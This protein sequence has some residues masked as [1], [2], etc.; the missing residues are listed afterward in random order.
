MKV[1]FPGL[2]VM[3]TREFEVLALKGVKSFPES[4]MRLIETSQTADRAF[5]S[6]GASH[7]GAVLTHGHRYL[8]HRCR[9]M[10]GAEEMHLQSLFP[11]DSLLAKFD[12]ATLCSLAGNAFEVTCCSAVNLCALL[13]LAAGQGPRDSLRPLQLPGDSGNVDD[14]DDED[15][16]SSDSL[17]RA[18]FRPRGTD[19]TVPSAIDGLEKEPE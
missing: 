15:D 6:D 17:I 11:P 3:T 1:Q 19:D 9:F 16:A 5:A 8:T 4:S 10:L 12:N 13:T 14:N 7:A 2:H 18:V